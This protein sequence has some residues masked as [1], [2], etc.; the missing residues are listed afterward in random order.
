[1][2]KGLTLTW[3]PLQEEI[4][5]D[6]GMTQVFQH[7]S[8]RKYM[9]LK[10]NHHCFDKDIRMDKEKNIPIHIRVLFLII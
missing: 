8:R 5:G 4:E 10:S 7:H 6:Q 9:I 1:M 3:T 2:E